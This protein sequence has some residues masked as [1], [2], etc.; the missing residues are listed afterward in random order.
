MK[1]VKMGK[2]AHRIAVALAGAMIALGAMVAAPT[3]AQAASVLLYRAYNPWSG[4]HIFTLDKAEYRSLGEQ[5]WT[6]EGIAFEEPETGS[7]VFRLYNP[8]SGD[9][10]YT[11]S[12]DEYERLGSQGWNQED[13]AFYSAPQGGR[14]VYRLYNP[15]VGIGTHHYTTSISEYAQLAT[16]GWRQ[17]GIA[18][19]ALGGP[20]VPGK[21]WV[22]L[23]GTLQKTTDY[24]WALDHDFPSDQV[25]AYR[26]RPTNLSML[27]LDKPTEVS[28]KSATGA[29]VTETIDAIALPNDQCVDRKTGQHLSVLVNQDTAYINAGSY[30][31]LGVFALEVAIH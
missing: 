20:D 19:Y 29:T 16:A 24:Q 8:F 21:N 11:T 3:T 6:Q 1:D 4:E 9:H 10:H 23:T 25:N 5:G 18:W 12:R 15:Y 17:E 26:A 27:V 2:F 28:A 14:P 22:S 7:P 13:I 31:P 30:E